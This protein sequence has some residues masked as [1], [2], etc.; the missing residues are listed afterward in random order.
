MTSSY[1]T[2][3]AT[4]PANLH[5]Q[6]ASLLA[7]AGWALADTLADTDKVFTSLGEDGK[8]NNV[9]RLSLID[10]AL[11]PD[12]ANPMR[13][14]TFVGFRG[15]HAWNA[16]THQG[17]N[18]WGRMGP[19]LTLGNSSN[20]YLYLARPRA[21]NPFASPLTK[22]ISGG[23]S[24]ATHPGSVFDGS[25][26]FYEHNWPGSNNTRVCGWH[27]GLDTLK[28]NWG[29][30]NSGSSNALV[31]AYDAATDLQWLYMTA[32][33]TSFVRFCP[34]TG[35]WESLS[36]CPF[37][38]SAM[39]WDGGDYIY[40]LGDGV[41]TFYRYQISTNTWGQ[42]TNAPAGY[43]GAAGAVVYIPAAASTVGYDVI[44]VAGANSATGQIFRVG[45][46]SPLTWSGTVT[47]AHAVNTAS[48]GRIGY[49][50]H[51]ALYS[52]RGTDYAIFRYDISAGLTLSGVSAGTFS[53]NTQQLRY[54]D[55]LA[56]K[57]RCQPTGNFTFWAVAN[58][59]RLVV[60]TKVRAYYHWAYFGRYDSSLHTSVMKTTGAVSAGSGVSVPV[61]SSAGYRV[62]DRV[63]IVDPTTGT[64][65]YTTLTSVP[66]GT[67]FTATLV[68]SYA[69][70]SLA[71]PNWP[72]VSLDDGLLGGCPSDAVGYNSDSLNSMAKIR[73]LLEL[74]LT[75]CMGPNARNVF[76]PSPLAVWA[77][78]YTNG[79]FKGI[80]NGAYAIK[81]SATTAEADVVIGGKTYK[82][83]PILAQAPYDTRQLVVGP[84]D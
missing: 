40:A 62:G 12:K 35:A 77:D 69:G 37:Q 24:N 8:A 81:A 58:K 13:A 9:L 6:L 21:A 60:V 22:A 67:H 20:Y 64:Y 33:S 66:D 63:F 7:T 42:L 1:L 14:M 83:F 48:N 71:Q 31:F 68:N 28:S 54:I 78:F 10:D 3:T 41:V 38:S 43:T 55:A 5:E 73:P 26:V 27:L 61:D 45:G 65:E 47:F 82:Y 74:A 29:T 25:G 53:G 52:M 15:Y 34:Q 80:L 23:T 46:A 84:I 39:V 59:D 70:G 2:G 36:A 76:Q 57:I 50:G 17:V 51:S 32:T 79:E 56:G 16:N 44:I 72:A 49:D 30:V 19:W 11:W 4:S 18:E 75:N